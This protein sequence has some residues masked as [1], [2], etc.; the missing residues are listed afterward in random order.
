[1]NSRVSRLLGLPCA[2]AILAGGA[3]AV[4]ADAA[5][6]GQANY[7]KALSRL[8]AIAPRLDAQ[9]QKNLPHIKDILSRVFLHPDSATPSEKKI[10]YAIL[11]PG[12]STRS[13]FDDV[14]K[15]A[16]ATQVQTAVQAVVNTP[17]QFV[18]SQDTIPGGSTKGIV[19]LK[20]P[21]EDQPTELVEIPAGSAE[22]PVEKRAQVVA[23][24][25]E[26][27]HSTDPLWWTNLEVN[28]VNNQVV[29]AVKGSD[30]KYVITADKDFAKLQ[31]VTPEVLA[32]SLVDKIR[33]TIDP[34]TTGT[35][36]LKNINDLSAAKK[37]QL[38]NQVRQT[39]DDDYSQQDKA[40]AE[41]A[42]LRAIKISP[43]YAV[44]YVRLADLYIE[45]NQ[46]QKAKDIL[47]QAQTV[48]SMDAD[49]KATVSQKFAE[50][51]QKF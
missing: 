25:L 45:E 10:A 47:Q 23:K 35:R 2:L 13:I 40:G 7:T 21:D 9:T 1:M 48:T 44:P 43:E 31:G 14:T 41:E 11:P 3:L 6:D 12:P 32:W 51:N 46:P 26:A 39:G 19:Y 42:Y 20:N 22:W 27:A 17:I 15:A 49:S 8:N 16:T 30:D 37:L 18:A 24:R 29:V 38:A 50:V 5:S 34:T 36:S 33:S 28:R 4:H